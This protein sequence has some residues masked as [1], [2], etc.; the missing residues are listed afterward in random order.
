VN[1]APVAVDDTYTM[2]EDGTAIVLNPLAS[3]TDLDGN[4]LSIVSING[5]TLTPGVAQTITVPNGIVHV[6]VNGTITFA[7]TANF[8]GTASFAYVI[9]DGTATAT[10]NEIITVNAVNDAPVAVTDTYT[11]NED[12]TAI[13]LTPLT[14][15]V[16]D[17][18]V[19][20]NTLSIVS[21]NGTD[22]TP[23]TAQIIAVLNGTVNVSAAG[24]ITFTP[25]ANFNGTVTIPYI[26]TD[27]KEGNGASRFSFQGTFKDS[28]NNISIIQSD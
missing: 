26:I 25:A 2:N 9:T 19:D 7:P 16:D 6:A 27:G 28:N 13:T 20:G 22:L 11:M 15:G 14:T 1:D 4:S 21:I 3:D 23:G 17:S 5:T 10:A 8:N 18:D 12:G 24:G